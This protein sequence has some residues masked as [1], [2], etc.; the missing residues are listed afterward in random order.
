MR[1]HLALSWSSRR[2]A[3][4]RIR[5]P[6]TAIGFRP[7]RSAFRTPFELDCDRTARATEVVERPSLC[8]A[9]SFRGPLPRPHIAA[10]P[11]PRTGAKRH[12]ASSPGLPCP[13]AHLGS[14][15]PHDGRPSHGRPR[16]TCGVWDPLRGVTRRPYRRARRR[17]APGLLPSRPSPR[18]GVCPSR[19]HGPPGVR[20]P[21]RRRASSGPRPRDESV[22]HRAR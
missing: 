12:E 3:G 21:F 6:G 17:S 9:R 7:A 5:P 10:D 1:R 13:T 14:T 15:D 11:R 16:F 19:S 18:R 22:L 20:A 8:V 2:T 4:V